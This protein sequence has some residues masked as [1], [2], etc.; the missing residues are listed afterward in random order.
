MAALH[1]EPPGRRGEVRG[2]GR[3]CCG[4]AVEDVMEEAGGERR[5]PPFGVPASAIVEID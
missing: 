4:C 1:L 3:E 5:K 2:C